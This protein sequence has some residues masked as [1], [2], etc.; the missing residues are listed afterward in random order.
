[1]RWVREGGLRPSVTYEVTI[2]RRGASSREVGGKET[3]D[4]GEETTDKGEESLHQIPENI[5]ESLSYTQRK[6]LLV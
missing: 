2:A 3:T 5:R 4:K 1:M 6:I